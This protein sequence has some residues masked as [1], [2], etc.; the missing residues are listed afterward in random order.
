MRERWLG[1][2]GRRVPEIAV[3]GELELPEETLVVDGIDAAQL[4]AAHD[5]GI[6]YVMSTYSGYPFSAFAASSRTQRKPTSS[7]A[8]SRASSIAL[9]SK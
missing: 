7:C 8:R 6:G 3:E 2:T 9:A 5:A 1:A 4:K